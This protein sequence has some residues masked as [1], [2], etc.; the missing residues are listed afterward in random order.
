MQIFQCTPIEYNW[1]GWKGQFGPHRCLNV[2][3]LVN[4]AAGFSIAQDVVILALPLPLLYGLNMS[5]RSKVGVIIMFSLG[6][7]ITITS[8]IRLQYLIT[9]AESTNPTWDYA[10]TLIWSGLEVSVSVIVTSLPTLRMFF[11][12]VLPGMFGSLASRLT[13]H[14]SVR[15]ISLNNATAESARVD[16]EKHGSQRI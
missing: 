3:M 9:F 8:C 10:D 5:W 13:S 15:V 11:K 6:I 2:N 14:T 4:V 1:L 16:G 12:R 7:F